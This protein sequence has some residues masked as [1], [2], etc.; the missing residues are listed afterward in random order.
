MIEE[1]TKEPQLC[2]AG[3]KKNVVD[4][5][6]KNYFCPLTLEEAH[7]NYIELIRLITQYMR[8]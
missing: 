4:A 5:L 7:D 2:E 8:T 6:S 1:Y 3:F